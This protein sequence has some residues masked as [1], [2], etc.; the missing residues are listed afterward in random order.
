MKFKLINKAL[1]LPEKEI[2]VIG[3]LHLGYEEMLRDLGLSLN[4]SK[5]YEALLSIGESSVQQIS[6]KSH[7]HRRNVYDSLNKLMD[8]GLASEVFVKGT[9][10]EYLCDV[11]K[12]KDD[13]NEER[14]R[15]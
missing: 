7:V 12:D 2:L 3:D 9:A 5:I 11:K 1:Y 8:K 10:P 15:R 6:L 4:E 14:E 13:K